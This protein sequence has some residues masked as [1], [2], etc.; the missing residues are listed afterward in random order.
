MPALAEAPAVRLVIAMEPLEDASQVSA[1]VLEWRAALALGEQHPD[2]VSET[3]VNLSRNDVACF[4]YTSGTGGK[5][6]GVMLSH[7]N[8]LQMTLAYLADVRSV[9]PGD[10]LLH[11]APLSHGSGLYNFAYVACAGVNVVPAS[12]S[13]D[14]DE[15]LDLARAYPGAASSFASSSAALV[16]AN[17]F[18]SKSSPGDR[19]R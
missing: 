1:E 7:G 18:V 15:V 5:P 19:F 16:F 17:S 10:A 11:A 9:A 8:L 6:K 4:I 13:F 2:G 14:A 3:V 12:R